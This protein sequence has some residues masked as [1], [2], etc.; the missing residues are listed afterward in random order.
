[1]SVSHEEFHK[2]A[3]QVLAEVLTEAGPQLGAKLK[4][5][6]IG[7]LCRRLNWPITE[8]RLLIPRLS[9]FLAAHSDLVEVRRP[10]GPGDITV[11]LRNGGSRGGKV[12]VEASHTWYHPSVWAAF[13][14]PDPARRRFL[15]RQSHEVVH[16]VDQSASP[17]NP[18]FADRVSS[19]K[20]FVEIQFARADLQSDWMRE[21][22]QTS[23]LIPGAEKQI[24]AHFARLPFISSINAAFAAALGP[25]AETWRRFRAHK[26]DDLISRWA[27]S[28]DIDLAQLRTNPMAK[29]FAPGEAAKAT[30]E[31]PSDVTASPKAVRDVRSTLR[32]LVESM[33]DAELRSVLVPLSAI[34]RLL[35][36]VT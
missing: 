34:E 28:N 23:P 17:P 10:I 20:S 12:G 1:M 19:D 16:F 30:P 29:P 36:P 4:P 35:R 3:R 15:H 32:A 22:L 9:S 31:Q 2:V 26:I 5:R 21:F 11:Q 8:S 27:T 14:N 33:D 7:E 18:E 25:H 13:V 24:A 6:L